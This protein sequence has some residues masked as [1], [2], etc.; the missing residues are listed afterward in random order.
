MIPIVISW[1]VQTRNILY[2]LDRSPGMHELKS[3]AT[4]K[5]ILLLLSLLLLSSPTCN[6]HKIMPKNVHL[7]CTL[8]TKSNKASDAG[9][10][11]TDNCKEITILPCELFPARSPYFF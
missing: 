7:D 3:K 1:S 5:S 6:S 11:R 4:S 8:N 10:E 2:N 9:S